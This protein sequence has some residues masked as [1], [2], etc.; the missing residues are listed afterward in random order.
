MDIR[1]VIAS[2]APNN[3]LKTV[4]YDAENKDLILE[5]NDVMEPGSKEVVLKLPVTPKK[6]IIETFSVQRGRQ[7][8]GGNKSFKILSAKVVPLRTWNVDLGSGD[9]EF[10]K[11]ISN[12]CRD[13]PYLKAN[14]KLRR[15]PS[16]TFKIV[17]RDKLKDENGTVLPTPCMIGKSSGTIE[18]SK[19]YFMNMSQQ[20]RIATLFHEYGHF[21]KNPL[22]NLDI[23]DEVGADLNGMTLHAGNGFSLSEYANA[24]K[25]V[26]KNAPTEQNRQRDKLIKSFGDRVYNGYYFGRPYNIK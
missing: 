9:R 2:N 25:I 18:V 22:M 6:L 10:T 20:Q 21:Y 19:D 11:F 23:G 7:A 1:Y 5:R 12:F 16:G 8:I 26:F 14:G 13:L 3:V 17:L 15:S 24:F 4:V